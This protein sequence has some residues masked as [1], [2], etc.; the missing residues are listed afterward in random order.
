MVATNNV[1]ESLTWLQDADYDVWLYLYKNY[2]VPVIN[3]KKMHPEIHRPLQFKRMFK[4]LKRTSGHQGCRDWVRESRSYCRY[5]AGKYSISTSPMD[6]RLSQKLY[7]CGMP[8]QTWSPQ[9]NWEQEKPY[10]C[11]LDHHQGSKETCIEK[12]KELDIHHR[13]SWTK[14]KIVTE[15][16]AHEDN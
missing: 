6:E 14:G 9:Y 7:L 2:L 8:L 16:L 15:M 11:F 13:K 10:Q 1:W 4:N 5:L 3:A 12:C